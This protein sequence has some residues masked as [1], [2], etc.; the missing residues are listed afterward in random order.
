MTGRAVKP[1]ISKER[2]L[3]ASLRGYWI[4]QAHISTLKASN[5]KD[6]RNEGKHVIGEDIDLKKDSEEGE[7]LCIMSTWNVR[8]AE[9]IR[10]LE[11]I[12]SRQNAFH[13]T[14]V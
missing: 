13:L 11:L 7:V 1:G 12:Q 8:I 3:E 14:N 4:W 10:L 6:Q 5:V 2:L 9:L